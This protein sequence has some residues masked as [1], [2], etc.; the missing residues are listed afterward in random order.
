MKGM[1]YERNVIWSAV[2]EIKWRNFSGSWDNCL[3]LSSKC[4]DHI[5]IWLQT[6]HFISH[7]FVNMQV[8]CDVKLGIDPLPFWLDCEQ[9]MLGFFASFEAYKMAGFVRRRKKIAAMSVKQM[10]GF[11][12]VKKYFGM[13]GTLMTMIYSVTLCF[14]FTAKMLFLST[15]FFILK[16][17]VS[18][19][20]Q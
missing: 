2:F 14:Y 4:E 7:F 12:L 18:P 13:R 17:W 8:N 16:W 1:W 9:K 19:K 15:S 20:S 5:F 11:I 3:K 10:Q 6:P